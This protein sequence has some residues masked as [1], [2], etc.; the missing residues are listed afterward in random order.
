[1]E[2]EEVVVRSKL[3]VVVSSEQGMASETVVC[4]ETEVVAS[5]E[6]GRVRETV[7]FFEPKTGTVS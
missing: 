1:M 7:V 4:D 5:D 6:Q 2:S 3:G